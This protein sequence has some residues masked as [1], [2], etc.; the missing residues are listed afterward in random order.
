MPIVVPA[1]SC[2]PTDLLTRLPVDSLDRRWLVACT[3]PRQEKSLARDL[4]QRGIPFYLPLLGKR[5]R[6]RGRSTKS[7][8]PLFSGFVFLYAND[9]ERAEA[10]ATGRITSILDVADQAELQRDLAHVEATLRESIELADG[11]TPK[12][13]SPV[14]A[15]QAF[16][17]NGENGSHGNGSFHEATERRLVLSVGFLRQNIVLETNDGL[18]ESASSE[19]TSVVR[20]KPLSL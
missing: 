1:V 18:Q 13:N 4:F 17:S 20:G 19:G 7:Y 3:M 6:Y 9:R 5:L 16:L 15:K 8:L 11:N 14:H 10:L 12:H 2:H